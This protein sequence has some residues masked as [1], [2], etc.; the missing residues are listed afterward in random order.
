MSVAWIW[1][2][3]GFDSSILTLNPTV[4]NGYYIQE[5]HHG[6][7]L[8]GN[9]EI[10]PFCPVR[11]E[12]C[13]NILRYGARSIIISCF[14]QFDRSSAGTIHYPY[15]TDSTHPSSY[16][17][18][19]HPTSPRLLCR[20]SYRQTGVAVYCTAYNIVGHNFR[21]SVNP[22]TPFFLTDKLLLIFF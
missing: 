3:S 17:E 12:Q 5:G 15:W 20:Q 9:A 11:P 19:P 14:V 8:P 6:S 4:L 16:V 10:S 1:E 7:H 2:F 21:L 18:L 22:L 13:G